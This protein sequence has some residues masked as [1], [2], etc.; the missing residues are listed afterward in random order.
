LKKRTKKLLSPWGATAGKKFFASFF[1]K[2]SPSLP[3]RT[4]NHPLPKLIRALGRW[5]LTALTIN[6]TIGAGILGLP[7]K[8]YAL[9]GIYSVLSCL[10]GGMLVGLVAATYAEAASRYPGTGAS[11]LYARAAFGRHAAF[12]AGWLAIVTRVLSFASITNL[13]I[14]YASGILPGLAQPL[15]RIAAITA[16]TWALG[17][18]I[19]GGVALAARANGAFTIGKLTLLGGFVVLGVAATWPFHPGPLPPLP[20]PGHWAPSIVLM[21]FGLIGM[22]SAVV[23]GGEMRNPRADIPVGLATGMLVTVALYSAILLV[24][25]A[26]VPNLATSQRPILDGTIAILGPAAGRIVAVC[27]VLI[28]SGTLFTILFVGPRLVFA[29]ATAGQ[30]PAFL[31]RIHPRTGTPLA[32]IL[33]H[34]AAAWALAI[35]STFLGALTAST[36]TRLMLYALTAASLIAMRRRRLSDQPHPLKLPGGLAIAIAAT[37]LCLWL[38]TQ[39]DRAAWL[40]SLWCLALGAVLWSGFGRKK[41]VLL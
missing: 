29:L 17:G 10:A 20:A 12:A 5:D 38:L 9:V 14:G 26:I 30:L 32:A 27:A 35:G 19:A 11:I 2:R 6:S 37:T 18:I 23:N 33:L 36:V 21:L 4:G 28:M 34:T 39:A 40:A 16:L 22:D 8:V 41:A 1:Q 3:Q 15:P 31:A 24:C 13:A 7:G 25:A